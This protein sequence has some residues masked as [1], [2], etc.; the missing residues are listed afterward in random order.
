MN[1]RKTSLSSGATAT[2]FASP[3]TK[4]SRGQVL[5][6]SALL[7]GVTL[8]TYL[9]ALR[10][11]FI[12]DDDTF[13]T[14]NKLIKAADG[15]YRFWFTREAPD[16]WPVTS[17]TLWLE[18]RLWGMHALG[19][20][21]TNLVLHIG[22]ALLL[23][24]LL[25]RLRVPGAFLAA[26]LFAVHP[27][28]VESVAWIT[29]RK[30]LM[31][32]LFFL[33][34]ILFFLKTELAAG[35]PKNGSAA[36]APPAGPPLAEPRRRGMLWYGL[37]LCAFALGMLSKGSVAMLPVVLLGLLAWRRRLSARDGMALLPFFAVAAVFTIVDIWFQNH[38]SAEA[39]RQAGV[40]ERLA[41][42][43]A[44]VW[45]YL[46][47]LLVPLNLV[48]IYPQWRIQANELRW[49]L[50]PLAVLG[51]SALL[52]RQR[53]GRARPLLFAWGYFCVM[54]VPVMGLTDTY[55]MKFS[56]V[57]D[58]YAHLAM[59]GV[60][61]TV[62]ASWAQWRA[63]TGPKLLQCGAAGP[64]DVAAGAPG[65]RIRAIRE[66][67][68]PHL[69]AVAVVSCLACLTWRQSGIYRDVQTLY[70]TTLEKNPGCWVA[71]SNLAL[72]LAD[73]GHLA[74]AI[75]QGEEALRL[76]PDLPEAR[77]NLGRALSR[78]GRL[79]EA[80]VQY[81]EAL[82]L[83]PNYPEAQYNLGND[84]RSAG[85]ISEAI[86][87]Y[88]QALRLKPDFL[89]ARTNLAN[90]L[91]LSG[92]TAEAMA[93]YAEALRIN[94]ADAEARNNLGNAL[95]EAGRLPEAIAQFGEALRLE[96]DFPEAHNNLGMALADAGRLP[97]AL[98]HF[99][100]AVRLRPDYAE[101]HGNLGAVLRELGR[102]R[103]AEIHLEEARRLAPK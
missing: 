34:A 30:N 66:L 13:L 59:I 50:A 1:P 94:P 9:P 96:P 89:D 4:I 15:L 47:K 32:M 58:H 22:E 77:Y 38:G 48:F 20:H 75:A 45:F 82:R 102:D 46:Y 85:R 23:W 40:F 52:W 57:A 41:G 63:R 31:A 7:C 101:A 97:E 28:N 17:T 25:D 78:A 42:A 84:L 14:Q 60:L 54:L 65:W 56:L 3:E 88:E 19:Y 35:P 91:E 79:P 103:E 43:G 37:S 100:Q 5:L 98:S 24:K 67:R 27:V 92:R 6:W 10:G 90:L 72:V 73:A 21:A 29:Q 64:Q 95:A 87:R 44:V 61:A 93:Q 62:A 36:A 69:A 76:K 2:G 83:R 55:F 33:L 86:E 12:W 18:W 53:A 70:E 99:E 8:A 80:I 39:I 71:R 51:V 74:E 11:G 49:W 16:Y 68:A 26:L 81:R